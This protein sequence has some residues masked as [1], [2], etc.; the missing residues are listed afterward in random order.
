M[1][2]LQFVYFRSW[3]LPCAAAAIP[4]A[5]A[6]GI[7]YYYDITPKVV[8]LYLGTAAALPLVHPRRLFASAHGRWLCALLAASFVSALVS[9]VFSVRTDLSIFGTSWRRFGL[10]T[11]SA[12]LLF[13]F[14]VAADLTDGV[15]RLR[16]YLRASAVATVLIAGY[17]I[18]QYSGWDPWIDPQTYHIGTGVWTIVRPPGT[19]GYVTYYANYLVFG[20]FQGLALYRIEKGMF[21]R[22]PAVAAAALAVVAIVL[23][24]TRA[25]WLALLVGGLVIWL[26]QARRPAPRALW[27]AGALTVIAVC[28]YLSPAGL[29]LRSRMRWVREDPA[30]GARLYLWRDSLS[31]VAEH[32]LKGSGPETFSVEFPKVQSRELSRAFPEFYHESAHNIF[33]D[34]ATA[35]GIPGLLILV[36][37]AAIGLRAARRRKAENAQLLAGFVAI[38]VC[39]Q[40]S[41]FTVSTALEFW[42][43]LAMLMVTETSPEPALPNRRTLWLLPVSLLLAILAVRMTIADWHLSNA[44]NAVVSS[45]FEET[46]AQYQAATNLGLHAD[47]WFSRKLLSANH[48]AEA[49]NWGLSATLTADDPYNAWMNLGLIFAEL[50]NADRTEYCIR[51]AIEASPAWYKPHLALAQFLLATGHA[52][53]GRKEMDLAR[54]LNPAL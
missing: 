54:R 25:A 3:L 48:S 23:S 24:G 46:R 52:A 1:N 20:A 15:A 2:S 4:L 21:W 27:I 12:L 6:P 13:A 47:L 14:L 34:A 35:Q 28:F 22:W 49:L 26:Y 44:R 10:I 45:R 37:A 43:M 32:W 5:I 53:E 39:Q 30:G 50:G 40:F 36:A 18:L 31:L 19:L 41:V 29:P 33:L 11:E 38:L 42:M 51:K 17:G 8:L 7:L 16:A 9:S